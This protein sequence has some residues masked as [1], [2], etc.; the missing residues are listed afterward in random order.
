ML[1]LEVHDGL[2]AKKSL[3][4]IHVVARHQCMQP[5]LR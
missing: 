1:R 4:C 5:T 2:L 3:M